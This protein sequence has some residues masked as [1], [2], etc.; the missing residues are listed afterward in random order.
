MRCRRA[1]GS[2]FVAASL[3]T[4]CAR[5]VAPV[6]PG[7]PTEPRVSWVI[8]SGPQGG[9]ESDVCR[10]DRQQPCVLPASTASRPISVV[11]AVYMYPAG[12]PTK[13]SGAFQS[14]FIQAA[15]GAGY[16]AKVDY[17]SQP[18]RL[19]TGST[20]GGL[21]TSAQGNY[22]F[23]IALFAEVPAHMDPHQF[24]ETIPVR[25]T[26]TGASIPAQSRRE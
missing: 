12:A 1:L 9:N 2:A 5:V 10:S 7:A 8:R 14:T 11:V 26:G 16:E 17:S 22:E 13:Y 6:A 4:G 18:G 25:V 21:V 15:G 24:Q 20:A 23:R 19:P 3:V